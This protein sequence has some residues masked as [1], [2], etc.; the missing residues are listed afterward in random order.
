MKKKSWAGLL[1]AKLVKRA[2]SR[3]NLRGLGEDDIEKKQHILFKRYMRREAK[4]GT[5]K[6]LRLRPGKVRPTKWGPDVGGG[7]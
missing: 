4:G 7:K 5:K 2:C 3:K 6:G 1:D